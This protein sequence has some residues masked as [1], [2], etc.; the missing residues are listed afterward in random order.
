MILL[1]IDFFSDELY[2]L[3]ES[4]EYF[5]KAYNMALRIIGNRLEKLAFMGK[6][7][8]ALVLATMPLYSP[9]YRK[10]LLKLRLKEEVTGDG[11]AI[12]NIVECALCKPDSPR[13]KNN[14]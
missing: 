10:W 9:E 1:L 13:R 4:N 14:L 8:K 12:F 5:S 3:T 7:D 2:K 11:R 6:L